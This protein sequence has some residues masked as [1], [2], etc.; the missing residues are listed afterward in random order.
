MM[1]E[2]R[3]EFFEMSFNLQGMKCMKMKKN[4]STNECVYTNTIRRAYIPRTALFYNLQC[5]QQLQ[6]YISSE[7]R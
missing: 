1:S 4:T 2:G 6:L 5:Q 7:E 3:E